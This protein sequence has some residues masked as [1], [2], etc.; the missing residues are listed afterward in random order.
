MAVDN[1]A[2]AKNS[3]STNFIDSDAVED[4]SAPPPPPPPP[5][6]NPWPSRRLDHPGPV[7][8]YQGDTVEARCNNQTQL[9]REIGHTIQKPSLAVSSMMREMQRHILARRK[10]IEAAEEANEA[11]GASGSDPPVYLHFYL[12]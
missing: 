3:A 9:S 2:D 11:T 8:G 1:R 5:L 4:P 10:A 7:R 6:L 12:F